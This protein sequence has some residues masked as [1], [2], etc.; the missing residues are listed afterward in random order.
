LI[1][2][3]TFLDEEKEGSLDRN[4]SGHIFLSNIVQAANEGRFENVDE[5]LL[6]HISLRHGNDEIARLMKEQL[7]AELRQKTTVLLPT[8]QLLQADAAKE[9]NTTEEGGESGRRERDA[10]TDADGSGGAGSGASAS[11]PEVKC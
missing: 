8:F 2:E 6:M 5:V 4:T 9:G 3:C 10:G 7:P 11:V 1:L